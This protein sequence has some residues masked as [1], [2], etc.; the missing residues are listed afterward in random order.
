MVE[1]D[2]V[3]ELVDTDAVALEG[4]NNALVQADSHHIH[5]E[6]EKAKV[7]KTIV[8]Q[9]LDI[10]MTSICS[11]IE[12]GQIN[13]KPEFQRRLR[14]SQKQKS[15]LVESAIMNVPI[16]PVFLGE[17]ELGKYVV[18]DG[19]QR[20]TAIYEFLTNKYKLNGL[21][22][23]PD[24]NGK[25]CKKLE[26]LDGD[27][28]RNLMRRFLPAVAILNESEQEVKYE[29]FDR[30]N[31]GGVVAEPMEVRNAIYRGDFNEQLHELSN[32]DC[33]VRL[34]GLPIEKKQREKLI[35]YRKMS[36]LEMVLRFFA[37]QNFDKFNG[38]IQ[39]FLTLTMVEKNKLYK[40]D[41]NLV[42]SGREVFCRA[43]YNVLYV[44]GETAFQKRNEEGVFIST[45]KSAPFADT[46]LYA[47]SRYPRLNNEIDSSACEG[48]RE[49]VY[50]LFKDEDFYK[51]IS[52]GTNSIKS[53]KYRMK[54][55]QMTVDSVIGSKT[56]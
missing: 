35:F 12:S 5:W 26:G 31:T 7:L 47:L 10:P 2:D 28:L 25:L 36:D 11:M 56:L 50:S 1:K 4:T 15:R 20:L 6:A 21:N 52:Y 37:M 24:L 48:V 29:V 38:S 40:N 23:W 9:K 27:P 42:V 51:A 18:L 43:H 3:E 8:T 19:R 16:P 39:D 44:F 13:L 22:V 53:T 33:F 41:K 30:L 32:D 49:A 54:K 46:L 17:D 45:Q 55:V 34:W 14:W